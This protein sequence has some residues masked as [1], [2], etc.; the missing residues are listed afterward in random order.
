[1]WWA[2]WSATYLGGQPVIG[3]VLGKATR[4]ATGVIS[5]DFRLQQAA[6]AFR[7]YYRDL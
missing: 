6:N 4:L 7:S 3:Y 1:M 2:N 5:L